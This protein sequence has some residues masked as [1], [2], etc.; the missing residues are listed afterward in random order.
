MGALLLASVYAVAIWTPLF[1]DRWRPWILDL[2]AAVAAAAAAAPCLAAAWKSGGRIRLGWA[3]MAAAL[4]S[5]CVAELTWSWFELVLGR[6]TPFPSAAD[7]FYL[8]AV[9]L[10]GT[11]LVLL[12]SLERWVA[13]GRTPWEG[14]AF[15]SAAN[16]V[17]WHYCLYPIFTANRQGWLTTS[18]AASYP[19]GDILLLAC[20]TLAVQ[21]IRADR[22]SRIIACISAGIICL[23]VADLVYA[24]AAQAGM[25]GDGLPTDAGWVFGYLLLGYAACLHIWSPANYEI[26]LASAQP[27]AARQSVP[28]VLLAGVIG[29]VVVASVRDELGTDPAGLS[30]SLATILFIIARQVAVLHENA[31]LTD[32]LTAARSDL[33]VK[34]DERT[35]ELTAAV[36]ILDATTDIVGTAMLT[37]EVVYMN[38]AGRQAFGVPPAA[39]LAR[40][41][42]V[43]WIAPD[44][45]RRIAFKAAPV[46]F[47]DGIW[48]GESAVINAEGI[49]IP[50][51]QVIVTHKDGTGTPYAYSTVMRDISAQKAAQQRLLELASRD[52][53]TGLVN[54]RQFEDELEREL[55]RRKRDGGQCALLFIDLDS[56]KLVNDTLGHRTGDQ[57]LVSLGMALSETVRD[58]DLIGRLGGDEF[59]VLVPGAD[60]VAARGLAGRLLQVTRDHRL[61]VNGKGVRTTASIGI[62]VAPDHGTTAA[63]L[64]ANADIAMY[65]AKE[66]RD[67]ARVFEAALAV[68]ESMESQLEWERRVR[69]ALEHDRLHL[70]AQPIQHLS[71]ERRHYELLLRLED[72]DGQLHGPEEFLRIAE[73]TSL[74][75]LIDRAVTVSAIGLLGRHGGF[76]VEINLSGRAFTDDGLLEVI[77]GALREH[78]VAA[79]RLIFEITETAAIADTERARVFIEE[80]RELGCRF[81]LDDFGVGFSSYFYLK[82]LPVD[83]LKIDG[84]FVQD[85]TQDRADQHL[86][87][88]MVEL[89]RGLGKQTIAE[90][91]EDAETERLLREIGVDFGQGYH[92]ARPAPA[93]ELFA[94]RAADVHAARPAA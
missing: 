32:A 35:S 92:F 36:R 51:S 74:V 31:R 78:R 55:A 28:L 86:V 19:L 90:F 18:V 8:L 4:I 73:R 41:N 20:A 82:H 40:F 94:A 50:V 43:N 15:V 22:A 59:A 12:T 3:F 21:H 85:L 76:D 26:D 69:E 46:A 83:F 57:L 80:L 52:A 49:E 13:K 24:G 5:W 27:S 16:A 11:A 81:A 23:L 79:D 9:P 47:R 87:R 88:S 61:V 39:D 58:M 29:H 68:Q 33:E 67:D 25:Y 34:V 7:V 60:A 66:R 38:K 72:S 42:V 93:E 10:A 17:A 14:L 6:T 1:G 62:A 63:E 91:V 71:S 64:L 56:F 65:Q 37:G 70:F 77:R 44:H 30:L 53:L 84:S 48:E 75:H 54:R 89:A 45:Q 2:G